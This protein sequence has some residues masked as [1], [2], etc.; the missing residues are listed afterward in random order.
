MDLSEAAEQIGQRLEEVSEQRR[1]L[2]AARQGN[3]PSQLPTPQVREMTRLT[4]QYSTQVVKTGELIRQGAEVI[5]GAYVDTANAY[6]T[7]V[8]QA[9]LQLTGIQDPLLSKICTKFFVVMTDELG[10]GLAEHYRLGE[11]RIKSITSRSLEPPKSEPSREKPKTLTEIR[12]PRR[13]TP[14][15]RIR[16]WTQDVTWEEVD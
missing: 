12:T 9:G 5:A 6:F 4:N 7:A 1:A 16:G 8:E 11:G 10:A 2:P 13:L 3:T 15:E 14:G